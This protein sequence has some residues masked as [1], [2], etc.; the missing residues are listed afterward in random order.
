MS[1]CLFE[2]IIT[3]KANWNKLWRPNQNQLNIEGGY[4]LKTIIF[5]N[6]N[7]MLKYEIRKKKGT[8]FTAH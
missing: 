6:I 4:F 2:K 5:F 7:L 8:S 1:G 3:M